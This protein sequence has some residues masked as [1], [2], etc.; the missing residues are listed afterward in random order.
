MLGPQPSGHC[1]LCWPM[2]PTFASFLKRALSFP[3]PPNL[4]S[5]AFSFPSPCSLFL[6][7][8]TSTLPSTYSR[9][10]SS[11]YCGY[12]YSTPSFLLPLLVNSF[13]YAV[14]TS[15]FPSPTSFF[16]LL[17]LLVRLY[18]FPSSLFSTIC[19]AQRS[20]AV[21]FF[22]FFFY[23]LV[24]SYQLLLLSLSCA[25]YLA[26]S[27]ESCGAPLCLQTRAGH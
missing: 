16:S 25:Q 24:L 3:C 9:T 15:F 27:E 12:G 8:H 14:V 7:S 19:W 21:S 20:L 22:S 23:F 4:F 13:L 2:V 11:S 17:L 6:P 18:L 5:T 26:P 1:P 10:A